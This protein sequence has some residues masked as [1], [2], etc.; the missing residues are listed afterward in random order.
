MFPELGT[1]GRL[2][3]SGRGKGSPSPA[4]FG[5]PIRTNQHT[6]SEA[7]SEVKRGTARDGAGRP[8]MPAA[9]GVR[10]AVGSRSGRL[11]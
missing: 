2:I 5:G 1:A 4:P 9:S 8:G 6:G 11:R 3:Y 7:A 10:F